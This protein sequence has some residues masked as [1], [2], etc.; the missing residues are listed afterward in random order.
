MNQFLNTTEKRKA[1]YKL[2]ERKHV[3]KGSVFKLYKEKL[4]KRQQLKTDKGLGR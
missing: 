3:W 4:L 1:D 2:E